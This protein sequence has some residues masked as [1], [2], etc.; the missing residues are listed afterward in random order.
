MIL[1]YSKTPEP[2]KVPR[3]KEPAA[4]AAEIT[5][6][7]NKGMRSYKQIQR[8]CQVIV[9]LPDRAFT[10]PVRLP[11]PHV[12]EGPGVRGLFLPS[13]HVG[14]GSGVRG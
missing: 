5:P 8:S 6:Y 2:D 1:Q 7:F 9:Q 3:K 4:S 12:G 13:P 10:R 14:E 11:S